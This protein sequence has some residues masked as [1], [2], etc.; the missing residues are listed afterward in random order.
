MPGQ[1]MPHGTDMVQVN[2]P[3]SPNGRMVHQ[4][5]IQQNK[6]ALKASFIKV[7][8]LN[9][10]FVQSDSVSLDRTISRLTKT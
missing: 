9:R 3:T 5:R 7:M 8:F 2:S 4:E 6:R 1:L 10:L